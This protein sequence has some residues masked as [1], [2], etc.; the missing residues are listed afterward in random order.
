MTRWISYARISADDPPGVD[1]LPQ[2]HADNRAWIEARGG[3]CVACYDDDGISGFYGP[4]HRPGLRSVLAAIES[5]QADGAVP[6][7]VDRWARNR[8]H[9]GRIWSVAQEHEATIACRI[10]GEMTRDARHEKASHG[11]AYRERCR[12]LAMDAF[13]RRL[14]GMQSAPRSPQGPML[15]EPLPPAPTSR[16]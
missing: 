5:G 11:E 6:R 13:A 10:D 12:R 14:P 4:R 8:D 16:R 15:T 9:H 2:Q 3:V 7:D 1:K